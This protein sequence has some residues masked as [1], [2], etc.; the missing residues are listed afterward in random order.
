MEYGTA[1]FAWPAPGG[2]GGLFLTLDHKFDTERNAL[3][4]GVDGSSG[5]VGGPGGR[6]LVL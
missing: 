4:D 2:G 1:G 3:C 6:L 5:P